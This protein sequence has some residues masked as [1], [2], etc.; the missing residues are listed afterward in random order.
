[1]PSADHGAPLVRP[2]DVE[3]WLAEL[4]L[5]PARAGRSRRDRLLGP[6]A[7]R[8]PPLRPPRHRHPRSRA[9]DHRAG[10]TTPRRSATCSASRT[11]S[12]CAGTTS[13]RSRSS[14]SAR[15]SARCSRSRSR[16]PTRDADRLGLAL[17][18]ILGIAD[19]L[20]DESK[21]WIW[22]G[23]RV[24]DQGGR[25][26]RQR[27]VPRPV[28]ASRAAGAPDAGDERPVAPRP[29]RRCPPLARRSS[30]SWPRRCAAPGVAAGRPR[31]RGRHAGPD[32]RQ[33]RPLRR[34]ARRS[35]ASGSP[36]DLTLTNHLKDTKTK[37][38]YFD[39]AFLAV[40]PGAS[41][42]KFTWAGA[43]NPTRPRHQ[44]DQGL[45]DPPARPRGHGCTAARPRR[46]R[47]RFDLA[48]PGGE[49][50]RDIRDRRL[51]RRRSRSGR[52]RRD[53]TPGSIVN[54]RLPGRLHGRGRRRADSRSPRPTRPGG[55]S[56]GRAA[57]PSR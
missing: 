16:S 4:G 2:A 5:E 30:R 50:T 31:S 9:R 13:S 52:S 51:A 44:E 47:C 41:G 12:C 34:P 36:L 40:L 18:R 17:A 37:R 14:A 32:D 46:T 24:P 56:S 20:L 6:R 10:R 39:K 25:T 1:M 19:Q 28:R 22:I 15:T 35:T 38:Y 54:G 29:G 55:R 43:G 49:A 7:R 45:H 26:P 48:D 33:R 53:A 11:G 21:G 27:G 8:P 23:G 3:R 57:S 42:Y